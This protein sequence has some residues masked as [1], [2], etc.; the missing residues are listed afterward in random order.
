ME[1]SE[2]ALLPTSHGNFNARSFRDADGREH[3]AVYKGDLKRENVP[4]RVHSKCTTGD[5]FHSLRCDCGEQLARALEHIEKE[6]FGVL[7]YLD[8]E[9]RGIG[10]LNKVNAYRLQ[11][12]GSDT[13]EANEEL[14]FP[15]DMRD[16]RVAA[17]ILKSLGVVSVLLMTNN[18]GKIKG[19]VE[20]GV[21]VSDRMPLKVEPNDFNRKYLDTK[22]L[23]M[24]QL[25]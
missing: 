23:R 4:V 24:D 11:E 25:L 22:K 6:G 16:Y 8:Q 18:P 1:S 20:H 10:L 21:T 9:G 3:L 2:E 5:T 7:V 17:D 15:S 12:N 19:L 14:G 13:V